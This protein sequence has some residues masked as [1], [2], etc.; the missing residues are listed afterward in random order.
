MNVATHD[1]R[2]V[3]GCRQPP[4][5]DMLRAGWTKSGWFIR[6]P[7]HFAHTAARIRAA[8]SVVAGARRA[9]V[10]AGRSP[11]ARTDTSAPCPRRSAAAGCTCRR[12]ARSR[13]DHAD[14]PGLAVGEPVGRRRLGGPCPQARA[15]ST[16]SIAVP[17]SV[18]EATTCSRSHACCASSGMYSMNRTSYPVSR[19]HRAKP[20]TSSSFVPPI[21]TQLILIG[22][23]PAASAARDPCKHLVQRVAPRHLGEPVPQQGVARNRRA[24]DPG[25]GERRRRA[26]RA[27]RRWS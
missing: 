22:V 23:S 15:G 7:D 1:A 21:T 5:I 8:R 12:T 13:S 10:P 20:T 4:I 27:A 24:V 9:S 11:R 26:G 18:R 6:W 3:A 25:L 19:A 17:A 16:A 2:S 14:R